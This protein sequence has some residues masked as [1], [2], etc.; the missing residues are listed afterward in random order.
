VEVVAS[1]R[2]GGAGG[3]GGGELARGGG[4]PRTG[5]ILRE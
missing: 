4:C 5:I 3:A 2:A 1:L